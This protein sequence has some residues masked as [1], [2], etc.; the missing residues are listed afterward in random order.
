MRRYRLPFGE[1]GSFIIR[2]E[3]LA[4]DTLL[5]QNRQLLNE[6]D[7]KSFGDGRV[8]ARVPLNKLYQDFAGR[9]NDADFT[10]WYLNRDENRPFRTFRGKI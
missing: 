6:S 10:R 4:E 7:G 5:E 9:W 8:V 3:Y 1:E 2:T